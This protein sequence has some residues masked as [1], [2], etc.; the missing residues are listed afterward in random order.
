MPSERV[1]EILRRASVDQI[2]FCGRGGARYSSTGEAVVD[3]WG[4]AL[5]ARPFGYMIRQGWLLPG[6]DVGLWRARRL[7]DPAIEKPKEELVGQQK[8]TVQQT[9][10][11][12]RISQKKLVVT[13]IEG[14]K[15]YAYGDGL[16]VKRQDAERIIANRWVAPESPG[17]F[18]R[19]EDAQ[20]YVCRSL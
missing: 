20:T 5:D 15:T 11:L 19:D 17:L 9:A 13:I 3:G 16:P 12:R 7:D 10:V 6:D 18:G 4:D 1:V 14:K 2:M 8:P